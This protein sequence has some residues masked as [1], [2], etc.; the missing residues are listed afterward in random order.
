MPLLKFDYLK[1]KTIQEAVDM[2][3]EQGGQA[4]IL[5]GG[6]DLLV[7]MR[8]RTIRPKCLIDIKGIEELREIS[9]D[10]ENGL[11][12][13]AAVVLNQLIE[14]NIVREKFRAIW[15]ASRSLGDPILRNRATLVGNICNASPASD[16]APALLVHDAEVE[17][18]SRAGER[19]IP[20]REFFVGVKRTSL[21][22]DELVK[23]VRVPNPKE[24]TKSCYLKWGRTRGE[25]LAV[26]GVAGLVDPDQK[27][28][29]IALSS[30]AP[31]PLLIPEVEEVFR[32]GGKLAEQIN[33]AASVVAG[34]I[35]P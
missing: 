20:I 4:K 29:C 18:V 26:V 22:P 21:K 30:V 5:A 28:V 13:G 33:R 25:D 9:Q 7:L 1:P 14:S 24:G 35:S 34:K 15:D 19:F 16:T 23:S 12:I 32:E 31:T 6:T 8:D 10:K 2:L 27:R 17:V 11:R 3:A